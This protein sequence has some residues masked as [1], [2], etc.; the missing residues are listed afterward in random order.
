MIVIQFKDQLTHL[1]SMKLLLLILLSLLLS[2]YFYL[3][4]FFLLSLKVFFFIK[5]TNEGSKQFKDQ[6]TH[7]NSMKLLLLILLSLLLS[8]YF[9]SIYFFLLSFNVKSSSS[10]VFISLF[11][12]NL[13][14]NG[15]QVDWL[16]VAFNAFQWSVDRSRHRSPRDTT[17]PTSRVQMIQTVSHQHPICGF[18]LFNS[19]Q[20]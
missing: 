14:F 8:L 1:N 3:I 18:H 4:F 12:L 10:K 19:I 20:F 2:L 5:H 17:W 11:F 16:R 6:L 13:K 9:Y 7:L 15:N